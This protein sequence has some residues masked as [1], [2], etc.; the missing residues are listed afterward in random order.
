MYNS[1]LPSYAITTDT[2]RGQ[3]LFDE[4]FEPPLGANP[5][6]PSSDEY[7]SE[8]YNPEEATE[9]WDPQDQTHGWNNLE[10]VTNTDTPESPPMFEKEGYSDPVEY[11]DNA[12]QSGVEDID[13]RVLPGIG[14]M[15]K[16]MSFAY[17]SIFWG[18]FLYAL[19]Y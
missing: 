14:E 18:L 11:H 12:V 4:S 10:P 6:P 3:N 16:C 19:I 5:Y 2:T 13:Q 17:F 8:A 9:V 1:T 15:G 7:K